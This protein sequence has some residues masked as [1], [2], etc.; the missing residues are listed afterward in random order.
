MI[1]TTF[2]AHR[3]NIATIRYP[4]LNIATIRYPPTQYR[5]IEKYLLGS[6]TSAR[7]MSQYRHNT[8]PPYSISPH[9]KILTLAHARQR[10]LQDMSD[11]ERASSLVSNLGSRVPRLIDIER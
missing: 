1:S 5:H 8:P 7:S 6:A 10:L 4:L 11:S 9:S 2:C 3:L